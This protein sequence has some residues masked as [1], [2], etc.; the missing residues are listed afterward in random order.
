MGIIDTEEDVR[1]LRERSIIFNRL[2]S[3]EEVANML[4][5]MNDFK[6]IRLTKAPL[7]DKVIGDVNE[8]YESL[9]MVKMRKFMKRSVLSSWQYL[10]LLA[11]ILLLLL[12]AIESFC[13]VF[14]CYRLFHFDII[15]GDD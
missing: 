14:Q 10:T 7:L 3:D 8:Y 15:S 9:W 2:K 4:N 13:T 11:A 12:M 5:E 6:A 1:L